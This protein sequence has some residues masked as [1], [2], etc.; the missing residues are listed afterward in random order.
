MNPRGAAALLS[1]KVKLGADITAA[2]GPKGRA[3][4]AGTDASLRAEILT[5]SRARGLFAGVSLE[6][7]TLRPDNNANDDIYG[8]KVTATGIVRKGAVEAPP[9]ASTLLSELEK[10][11]PRNDSDPR[12]LK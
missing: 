10:R 8:K 9:A 2:A 4:E 11:S 6:G 12:S 7:A 3:I 5:Y 1:N